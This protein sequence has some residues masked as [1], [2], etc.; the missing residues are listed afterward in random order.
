MKDSLSIEFSKL[1]PALKIESGILEKVLQKP[2]QQPPGFFFLAFVARNKNN[3]IVNRDRITHGIVVFDTV[4]MNCN[5]LKYLYNHSKKF[6]P[7]KGQ[8]LSFAIEK[9]FH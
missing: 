4:E 6:S 3:N 7:K 2:H 9:R 1:N 8:G 5:Y